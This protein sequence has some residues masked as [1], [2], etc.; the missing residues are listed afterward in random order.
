MVYFKMLTL[1][2]CKSDLNSQRKRK[3]AKRQ[4]KKEKEELLRIT[5]RKTNVLMSLFVLN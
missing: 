4:K 3:I 1:V 2:F 5:G